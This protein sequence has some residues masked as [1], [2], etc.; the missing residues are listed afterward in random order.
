M[1]NKTTIP[2]NRHITHIED[3]IFE[4]PVN[5]I[6]F[7]QEIGNFLS[8]KNTQ[9]NLTQKWDGSP[10]IVVGIHSQTNKFFVG[11]KSVFNKVTPKICYTNDDIDSF[12]EDDELNHK[13]KFCLKY[14]SQLNISTI[15]Q[16][17]LLFTDDKSELNN[18]IAF[19]P[20]TITYTVS[21]DSDLG[22]KIQKAKIGIVFHTQYDKN[23]NASYSP[24][25][26]SSTNDVFV[27]SA[28]LPQVQFS[29]TDQEKNQYYKNVE[30]IKVLLSQSMMFLNLLSKTGN[31]DFVFTEIFKRFFNDYVKKQK[32]IQNTQDTVIDF[33]EYFISIMN[34]EI[35]SKKQQK[36]QEKYKLILQQGL[37]FI[38][39]NKQS[40]HSIIRLYSLIQNLKKNVLY[41]LEQNKNIGTLIQTDDGYKVTNSEGFVV[42]GNQNVIKLVDRLEFSYYNNMRWNRV[43]LNN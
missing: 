39:N 12:Y 9:I 10:S 21:K 16:G 37:Q 24:N 36:T 34:K 30:T 20:N 29:F 28:K 17:D 2:V 31:G 13:L 7:L 1:N 25:L 6:F 43:S 23:M 26:P 15:L 18:S 11:T 22:Q 8:S 3:L 35:E 19:K 27:T 33:V 41:K 14:L 4:S 32:H 38:Q 40:I 42:S 5:L